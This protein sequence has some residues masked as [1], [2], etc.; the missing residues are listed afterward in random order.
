[1]RKSAVLFLIPLLFSVFPA[2]AA[3]MFE[4]Y[5][6]HIALGYVDDEL[7][8]RYW[9]DP[10]WGVDM[11]VQ[12]EDRRASEKFDDGVVT[13]SDRVDFESYTLGVAAVRT[14]KNYEYFDLNF[15]AGVTYSSGDAHSNPEGPNNTSTA[16]FTTYTFYIGPEVEIRVPYFSRFVI[17][18][19]FRA[20]WT[21]DKQTTTAENPFGTESTR[22]E[23]KEFDL[24]GDENSL[25]DFTHVGIRYYF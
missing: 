4:A 20:S 15:K 7:N 14:F 12:L 22:E 21:N 24:Q 9:F 23:S 18:T 3:Q 1:M 11:S 25:R 17:V 5:P 13:A 8:L 2:H 16:E 10:A 19:S 6:K